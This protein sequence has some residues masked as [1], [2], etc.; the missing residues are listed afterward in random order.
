MR[1]S[2]HSLSHFIIITNLWYHC[3]WITNEELKLRKADSLA[4]GHTWLHMVVN[5]R[6]EICAQV[7]LFLKYILFLC[8]HSIT[9]ITS[10]ASY[11]ADPKEAQELP[12][13]V[14]LVSWTSESQQT[15]FLFSPLPIFLMYHY[16]FGSIHLPRIWILFF[17]KFHSGSFL[18]WS[19]LPPYMYAQFLCCFWSQS[20][21]TQKLSYGTSISNSSLSSILMPFPMFASF[22]WHILTKS[23]VTVTSC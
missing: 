14:L 18:P 17:G 19:I 1:L 22:P 21:A 15:S 8:H 12:G 11:L 9:S 5:N 3:S 7:C 20:P 23:P 4:H 6:I 13:H 10:M 2:L 16:F